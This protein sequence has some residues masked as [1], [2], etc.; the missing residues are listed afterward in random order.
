MLHV[1]LFSWLSALRSDQHN[2]FQAKL[3]DIIIIF[4][5]HPPVLHGGATLDTLETSFNLCLRI[6]GLICSWEL[7]CIS[8]SN[9]LNYMVVVFFANGSLADLRDFVAP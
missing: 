7:C 2:V 3:L 9:V 4:C 8:V 1:S 6:G 5:G